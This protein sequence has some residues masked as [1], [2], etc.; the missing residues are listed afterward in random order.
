MTGLFYSTD[1]AA[2]GHG[3]RIPC[4]LALATF[5]AALFSLHQMKRP[6]VIASWEEI[7]G[8]GV[9]YSS[10]MKGHCILFGVIGVTVAS[11]SLLGIFCSFESPQFLGTAAVIGIALLISHFT[12]GF[13]NLLVY[14]PFKKSVL[15]IHHF[16]IW[17]CVL[18]V[19]FAQLFPL[20][21]PV[22]SKVNSAGYYET[23]EIPAT[24]AR[25][26]SD[27]VTLASPYWDSSF[28]LK[29]TNREF[30]HEG[31]RTG[32]IAKVTIGRGLLF[33]L[34]VSDVTYEKVR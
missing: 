1:Y 15:F 32:D 3:I 22:L 9:S 8:G 24:V 14:P 34:A 4:S 19:A 10:R 17:L 2:V 33:M 7:S 13:K 6:F 16:M 29:I 21:V 27:S 26:S 28:T 23:M 5:F 20:Y 31:V 11:V 25:A 30:I 12:I 18:F